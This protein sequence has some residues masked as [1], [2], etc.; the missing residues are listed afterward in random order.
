MAGTLG[1]DRDL[2]SYDG[3]ECSE[4]GGGRGSGSGG[5]KLVVATLNMRGIGQVVKRT[6]VF[7]SLKSIL[8]DMLLIQEVHLQ[9]RADAGQ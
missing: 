5:A 8:F 7:Q 3:V 2:V 6:A 1:A 4:L 9:L